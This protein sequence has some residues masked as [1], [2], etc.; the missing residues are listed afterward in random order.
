MHALLTRD[1]FRETCFKRDDYQCVICKQ[2][3]SIHSPLVVHHIIERR[4]FDNGGYFERNGS[5]LCSKHHLEAEMTLIS[6]EEIRTACGISNSQKVIPEDLYDDEVYDKWADIILPN[7]QR[8][9]GPLF[10]DPNVQ[11]VLAEGNVL[12]LFTKYVKYPRTYHLS[13][14]PGITKDD[15]V[16][17]NASSVFSGREIVV[18]AKLDG[19]CTSLYSDYIHARSRND[20]PHWSKDWIKNFHAQICADIPDGYRIVVENL[21][22]KHSIKYTHLKS[23]CYGISVWNDKNVCLSWD[24]TLEWFA[25]L[26][27]EPVPVLYR[28]LW[29]ENK[30]KNLYTPML[31][32]DECEGYV[33]R[34]ADSFHYRDFKQ[35]IAKYVRPFHVKNE[36]HWFHGKIGEKNELEKTIG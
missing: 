10:D 15:R 31:N 29:D 34:L 18:S 27:I 22:A 2:P 11:K 35:S 5:T 24:D 14:S 33:V 1:Q 4:L 26:G 13:F 28:G 3:D 32:G 8:M 7:G 23:Y 12:H 19:E 6:V 25:L 17:K 30:I 9:R 20:K 16:L 36:E 21:Y